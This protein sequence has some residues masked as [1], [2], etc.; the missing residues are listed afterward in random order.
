MSYTKITEPIKVFITIYIVFFI[1]AYLNNMLFD[2]I[3]PPLAPEHVDSGVIYLKYISALVSLIC[4]GGAY[5]LKYLY[6]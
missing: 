6:K 4:T 2:L 5:T 1:G 3:D